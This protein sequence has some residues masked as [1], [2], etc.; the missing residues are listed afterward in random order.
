MFEGVNRKYQSGMSGS[1]EHI[2]EKANEEHRLHSKE[3]EK[4]LEQFERYLIESRRTLDIEAKDQKLAIDELQEFSAQRQL[5]YDEA[6]NSLERLSQQIM[7]SKAPGS[8]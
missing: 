3:A 8:D 2:M 7:S 5:L 6:I 1:I 4:D